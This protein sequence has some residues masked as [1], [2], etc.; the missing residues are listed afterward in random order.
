[1]SVFRVWLGGGF[2]TWAEW[3]VRN[4]MGGGD[5]PTSPR[6]PSKSVITLILSTTGAFAWYFFQNENASTLASVHICWAFK[7]SQKILFFFNKF[8]SLLSWCL[9]VCES[10]LVFNQSLNSCFSL[11]LPPEGLLPKV[12]IVTTPTHCCSR[13]ANSS[14]PRCPIESTTH[15]CPKLAVRQV[16][17]LQLLIYH[18]WT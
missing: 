16:D 11:Q 4:H 2:V 12:D 10:G 8:L 17:T 13:S 5:W 3:L 18:I 9:A 15:R 6:K 7:V 14:T 1:M